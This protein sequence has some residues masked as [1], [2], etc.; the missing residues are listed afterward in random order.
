MALNL[1]ADSDHGGTT[2]VGS[3][4]SSSVV[5]PVGRVLVPISRTT[6]NTEQYR[7]IGPSL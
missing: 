3:I 4:S 5:L 2:A 6:Q 1:V 7:G